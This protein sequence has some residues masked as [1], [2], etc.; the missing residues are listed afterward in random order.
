MRDG[1][2]NRK[3][4]AGRQLR[5]KE[6]SPSITQPNDQKIN[7]NQPNNLKINHNQPNDPKKQS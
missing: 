6:V 1:V 3:G 2:H 5:N 4:L 7:H